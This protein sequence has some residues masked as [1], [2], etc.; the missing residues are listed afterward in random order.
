MNAYPM[1]STQRSE[2]AFARSTPRLQVQVQG[3]CVT[4]HVLC[5]W[6][7]TLTF[8]RGV[9]E[10]PPPRL[11]PT[12]CMH[13]SISTAQHKTFFQ[14]GGSTPR[15]SAGDRLSATCVPH[16]THRSLRLFWQSALST[17]DTVLL[18]IIRQVFG[19]RSRLVS[20]FLSCSHQWHCSRHLFILSSAYR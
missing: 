12:T 9:P 17:C 7:H 16:T 8:K 20:T 10:I 2:S 1:N 5:R 15:L 4:D 11:H 6:R 19:R 13:T 3:A 18:S 14:V